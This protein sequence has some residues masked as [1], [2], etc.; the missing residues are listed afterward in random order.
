MSSE[1]VA[2]LI[3]GRSSHGFT[4]LEL[5]VA[6]ALITL[7]AV[8]AIPAFYGRPEV[9][10]DRA[11]LLLARDLRI[12][13][14]EAV[15]W[16]GDVHFDFLPDGEGYAPRFADGRPVPNPVGSGPMERI[17]ERD[18]VFE[19]V[20]ISRLQLAGHPRSIRFD[21]LGYA[22]GGGTIELAFEGQD[23][24]VIVH[25]S[26]GLVTLEGLSKPEE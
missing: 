6:L 18:A 11:A 2:R 3:G 23:C 22:Y 13:Q 16:S 7:V 5:A 19:G 1:P 21:R 14:N 26:S 15:R 4:V 24:R 12:A 25:E 9:T 8:L 20:R 17:Y 10:L